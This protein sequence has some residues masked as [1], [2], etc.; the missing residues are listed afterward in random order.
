[1]S[2]HPRNHKWQ[3]RGDIV[4]LRD[5]RGPTVVERVERC[6]YCPRERRQKFDVRRWEPVTAKG[7][8]GDMPTLDERE[9]AEQALEREF[10]A[11]T[12]LEE[13]RSK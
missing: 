1:M 13:L 5:R 9:T 4:R 3:M 8:K 6:K 7:Y 2:L 11:T 10:R 12:D